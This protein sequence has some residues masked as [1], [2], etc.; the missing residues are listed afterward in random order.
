M[1]ILLNSTA[2]TAAVELSYTKI[3]DSILND[4]Q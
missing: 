1:K 2:Y 3:A 4:K